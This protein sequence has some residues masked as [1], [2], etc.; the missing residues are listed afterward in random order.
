MSTSLYDAIAPIYDEWQCWNGMT[1]FA[2]V[3]AAKLAPLLEREVAA[4]AR[5][6]D[7]PALLD[8]GCGTGT[9]LGDIR[10]AQPTWRLA[11]VDAS[12]GMLAVAR[13]KLPAISDDVLW[14]RASLEALPFAAAFDVCTIFYDTLNHLLEADAL[15]RAFAAVAATLRPGGLLVFDITSRHGFEE[16]WNSTNRF[17]GTGWS[18]LVDARFDRANAIATGQVTFE[19]AGA[20]Q[21]FVIRERYFARDE[22]TAALG[23]TGFRVEAQDAWSPFPIGGLGKA[24]WVARLG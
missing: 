9:L 24:W 23:A 15:A 12:A 7:R 10:R 20:T 11:G 17:G 22:I 6:R 14:A 2:R 1:P 18:M 3:A 21:R 19:R 13:A 5:G 4:A 8:I 16:W